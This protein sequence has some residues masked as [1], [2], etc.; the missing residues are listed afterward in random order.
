MLLLEEGSRQS[1]CKGPE[2]GVCLG[3]SLNNRK[4]VVAEEAAWG[5]WGGDEIA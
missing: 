1:M 3:W 2:V 5:G 4:L